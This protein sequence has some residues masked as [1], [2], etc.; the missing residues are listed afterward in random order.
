MKKMY[1][2]GSSYWYICAAVLWRMRF[3]AQSSGSPNWENTENTIR[4]AEIAELAKKKREEQDTEINKNKKS[5][6]KFNNI[7]R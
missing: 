4:K 2:K 3:A 6:Q 5:K 1:E 7:S